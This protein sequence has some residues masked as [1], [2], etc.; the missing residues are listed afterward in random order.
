MM[1]TSGDVNIIAIEK[2][3]PENIGVRSQIQYGCAW[4]FS[5]AILKCDIKMNC[6]LNNNSI[7]QFADQ[8]KHHNRL[9]YPSNITTR[10]KIKLLPV[11]G[12]HLEFR[13]KGITGQGYYGDR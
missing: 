7:I 4:C 5:A 10:A 9:K 12:R 2:V 3:Y 1:A 6:G 13:G 8:K 11:F